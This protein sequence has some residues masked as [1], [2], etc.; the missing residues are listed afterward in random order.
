MRIR[1]RHAGYN[2]IEQAIEAFQTRPKPKD[3]S[4]SRWN[5]LKDG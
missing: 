1:V 4:K 3:V 5:T 2:E